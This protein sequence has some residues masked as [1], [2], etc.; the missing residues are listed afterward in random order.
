MDTASFCIKMYG[1]A[2]VVEQFP[3]KDLGKGLYVALQIVAIYCDGSLV[4]K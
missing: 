2:C 3:A 1:V 4:L